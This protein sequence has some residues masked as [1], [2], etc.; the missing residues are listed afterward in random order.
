MAITFVGSAAVSTTPNGATTAVVSK[1]AGVANGDLIIYATE[2]YNGGSAGTVS[3]SGFTDL[4]EVTGA[5]TVRD[6]LSV[7]YRIASSEPS[8]WT[9]TYSASTWGCYVLYVLRGTATTSLI[10]NSGNTTNVTASSTL[11]PPAAT[12]NNA[13]DAVVYIFSGAN[14]GKSG[15]ETITLP[16]SGVSNGVTSFG[17]SNGSAI[18][19]TWG[20]NASAPGSATDSPGP[21]DYIDA[22]M[23]IAPLV[24]TFVPSPPVMVGQAVKRASFY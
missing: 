21:L 11:P 16:T 3:S 24:A 15:T 14:A 23:D 6:Q 4:M 10:K 1:P 17:T 13:S 20:I 12:I 7:L 5:G 18:G 2:W 9:F 22:Y 8:T 19:V